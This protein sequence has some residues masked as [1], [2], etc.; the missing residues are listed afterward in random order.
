MHYIFF[1][2]SPPGIHQVSQGGKTNGAG[3]GSL[4][5]MASFLGAL[6]YTLLII[7]A[8]DA[9]YYCSPAKEEKHNVVPRFDTI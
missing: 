2:H 6:S 8:L 1:L 7:L 5:L 9:H 4:K 3:L